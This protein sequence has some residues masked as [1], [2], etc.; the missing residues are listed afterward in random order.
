VDNFENRVISADLGTGEAKLGI[1]AHLDTVAWPRD[2]IPTPLRLCTGVDR[3]WPGVAD[4]KGPALA[5]LYAMRCAKELGFL[6]AAAA[7][8]SWLCG[9]DGLR[10]CSS[11]YGKKCHA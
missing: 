6:S 10:R 9:G 11:L 3:F 2:G 7:D 1:L 8:S 5:A 4:D